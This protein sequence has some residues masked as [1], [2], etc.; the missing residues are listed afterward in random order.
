MESFP[1]KELGNFHCM[2]ISQKI[3]EW[4][5][6]KRNLIGKQRDCENGHSAINTYQ[7]S[8]DVPSLQIFIFIPFSG[9]ILVTRGLPL[10]LLNRWNKIKAFLDVKGWCFGTPDGQGHLFV[11]KTMRLL[12]EQCNALKALPSG[13]FMIHE[14]ELWQWVTFLR[15]EKLASVLNVSSFI[16]HLKPQREPSVSKWVSRTCV[17][18]CFVFF[19][20]SLQLLLCNVLLQS[21]R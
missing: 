10:S 12:C 7:F 1:K 16:L 21:E 6:I 18:W 5:Q 4:I 2:T 20:F 11:D 3:T 17:R 13:S 14:P 8:Q 9:C 19:I 15:R